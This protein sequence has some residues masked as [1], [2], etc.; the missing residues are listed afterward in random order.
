MLDK[1]LYN[2]QSNKIY[3]TLGDFINKDNSKGNEFTMTKL[4][5]IIR[6]NIIIRLYLNQ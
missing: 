3:S 2:C 6:R 4:L 1:D 5:N